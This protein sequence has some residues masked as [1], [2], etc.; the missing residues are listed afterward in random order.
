MGYICQTAL[1]DTYIAD[2]KDDLTSLPRSKMGS[3]CL[4]ISE[5]MEYICNS[6]GK[7]IARRKTSTDLSPT[8]YYTKTEIDSKIKENSTIALTT[9]EVL[10]I[11]MKNL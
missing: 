7:W 1:S 4:V 3:T 11:T 9:N 6:K 5:N 10:A 8:N 2:D